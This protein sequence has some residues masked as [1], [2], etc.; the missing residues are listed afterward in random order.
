MYL[1]SQN[2]QLSQGNLKKINLITPIET[3]CSGINETQLGINV[4]VAIQPTQG[5][6]GSDGK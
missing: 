4:I 5:K 3:L 1:Y 6:M 2:P